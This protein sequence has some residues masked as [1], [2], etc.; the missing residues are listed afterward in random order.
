V[1]TILYV[2]VSTILSKNLS[3]VVPILSAEVVFLQVYAFWC[4]PFGVRG[5]GYRPFAYSRVVVVFTVS[6][7]HGTCHVQKRDARDVQDHHQFYCHRRGRK[8][9][10]TWS[11]VTW[12]NE[13]LW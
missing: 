5:H 11:K 9:E 4:Q 6:K 8:K 7:K 10:I 13:V 1:E 2:L 12:F 3:K